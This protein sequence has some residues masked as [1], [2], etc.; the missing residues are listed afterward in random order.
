MEILMDDNLNDDNTRVYLLPSLTTPTTD[1]THT[2][3]P[4]LRDVA[5]REAVLKLP[6]TSD[7]RRQIGCNQSVNLSR[8]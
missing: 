8:R 7:A 5:G 1:T 4:S 6:T 3:L 2:P